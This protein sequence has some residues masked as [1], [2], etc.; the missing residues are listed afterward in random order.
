MVVLCVYK[1]PLVH[2]AIV[3]G[4]IRCA[5]RGSQ[6]LNVGPTEVFIQTF[7]SL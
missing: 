4:E 2:S 6:A 1:R 3:P 7:M 5:K